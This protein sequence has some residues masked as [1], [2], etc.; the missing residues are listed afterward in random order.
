VI[1]VCLAA[2]HRD[3]D[4]MLSMRTKLLQLLSLMLKGQ[5]SPLTGFSLDW[6]PYWDAYLT[7]ILRKDRHTVESNEQAVVDHLQA[8][9]LFI[10][11]A[12]PYFDA[13]SVHAGLE[14]EVSGEPNHYGSLVN[15]ALQQLRDV[16]SIKIFEGVTLLFA[17]LPT[18]YPHFDELLPRFLTSFFALDHNS[19]WM[20][21]WLTLF[22]RARKHST[23]FNW[24]RLL[25]ILLN[26]VRDSLDL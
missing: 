2:Y 6:K 26:V 3:H 16:R 5:W 9:M 25:P 8:L 1:D 13:F 15:C 12:R 24:Q 23:N 22:C 17:C 7:W 20:F 19:E 4:V 11:D 18:R 10:L 14:G 21:C